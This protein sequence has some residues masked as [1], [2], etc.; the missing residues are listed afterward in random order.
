MYLM[1]SDV[2]KLSKI[3]IKISNAL[4]FFE[5]RSSE[6][7]DIQNIEA[8]RKDDPIIEYVWEN[9]LTRFPWRSSWSYS[10]V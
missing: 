9:I 6:K 1:G 10:S 3:L 4:E 8:P 7:S 2:D 5:S